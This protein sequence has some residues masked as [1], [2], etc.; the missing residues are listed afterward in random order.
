ME[1]KDRSKTYIDPYL[2]GVLL[3]LLL[4]FTFY[5][6]GRGL[7]ASG[8]IK[9]TVVA[10][11]YEIAPEHAQNSE[12]YSRFIKQD[13][14]PLNTW[15]VFEVLGILVGAFASGAWFGRLKFKTE[16]S[17]KITKRT[18]LIAAVLG[19]ALFGVGA[20]FARGCTSGAALSGSA[21][22]GLS[23]F[24]TMISIF[25]VAYGVAY[26]FRKLWI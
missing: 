14:S 6:T 21:T 10:S 11:V 19:G 2:G 26:F 23:G 4:L 17:P 25:G 8:A 20:Q 7:G 9:N 15:M 22:L 13:K 24:L 1:N 5:I 18:R 16:H 3:G 12:Y